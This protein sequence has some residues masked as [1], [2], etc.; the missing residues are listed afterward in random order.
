[1]WNTAMGRVLESLGPI[2][3]AVLLYGGY[4]LVRY[5]LAGL[6]ATRCP[7]GCGCRYGTN[8]P[9]DRDCP[10]N[11]PCTTASHEDWFG[12]LCGVT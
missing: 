7:D 3:G 6:R 2:V 9:N 12:S 4:R 5:G 11:G 8:D 1:M 10:C